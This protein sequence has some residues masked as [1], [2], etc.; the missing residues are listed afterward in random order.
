M[1]KA[2]I[3]V[4]EAIHDPEGMKAYGEAAA[5]T[6][7]EHDVSVLAVDRQVEVLEGEWQG[8]QTVLLEFESVESARAWYTSDAYQAAARLRQ[9]AAT[10][11]VV[12][13]TG[14]APPP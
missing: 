13:L 5:P 9:A 4:S 14:I 11:D 7:A 10:T 1:P 8:D 6:I 3:I 2:Y 12:I